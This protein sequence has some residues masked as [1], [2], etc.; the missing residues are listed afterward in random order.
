MPSRTPPH[1]R[2][3][4]QEPELL[5]DVA[6]RELRRLIVTNEL[7]P[8]SRLSASATAGRLGLGRMPVRQALTRL[9]A[10]GLVT[11]SGRVHRVAPVTLTSVREVFHLRRLLEPEA[12][13]LA[14]ARITEPSVLEELE[15]LCRAGYD[16]RD[17]T[18]IGSFL[19][20]NTAFHVGIAE[21]ANRRLATVLR[22]LLTE[23]ERVFHVLLAL[24]PIDDLIAHEHKDLLNAILARDAEAARREAGEQ[25][26]AAQ[27]RTEQAVLDS[28][29]ADLN[30][31][32]VARTLRG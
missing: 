1:E 14:A 21:V 12:A 29:V 9:Q 10:E 23:Q 24:R 18:T 26:V 17:P 4:P 16:P 7:P 27:A 20:A 8:G 19:A 31:G 6:H 11:S 2:A 3:A 13:A 32:S 5:S 30:V 22:D 15:G 28:G 25:L